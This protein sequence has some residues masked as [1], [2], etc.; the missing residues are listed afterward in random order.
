MDL[1]DLWLFDPSVLGGFLLPLL[2]LWVVLALAM[3]KWAADRGRGPI[4]WILL[5]I[6]LT[7]AVALPLLWSLGHLDAPTP[8]A[9]PLG[10]T[11]RQCPSCREIVSATPSHCPNCGAELPSNE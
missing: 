10:S 7:P 1:P 11:V 8:H 6:V 4:R 3:G 5:G 9:A 2:L